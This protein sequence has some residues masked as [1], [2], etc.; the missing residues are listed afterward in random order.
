[1]KLENGNMYTGLSLVICNVRRHSLLGTI[2]CFTLYIFRKEDAID[3]NIDIDDH[4]QVSSTYLFEVIMKV[5]SGREGT[6]N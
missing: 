3:I 6:L 4:Y 1:M 5:K 2:S